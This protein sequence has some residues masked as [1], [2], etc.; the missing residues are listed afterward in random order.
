ML[1]SE[2]MANVLY[3][4]A[5]GIPGRAAEIIAASDGIDDEERK[6]LDGALSGGD[7]VSTQARRL[8]EALRSIGAE[9]H[10]VNECYR[11]ASYAGE[12]W[13]VLSSN[14]LYAFFTAD[15]AG[16]PLDKW[17]RYFPVYER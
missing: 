10:L 1:N 4:V 17:I 16:Y 8:G 11:V 7:D 2:E 13:K 12:D 14:P 9:R 6:V 5:I 3:A 15:R